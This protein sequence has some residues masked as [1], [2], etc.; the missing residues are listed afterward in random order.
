MNFNE[1][2]ALVPDLVPDIQA[3]GFGA[4]FTQHQADTLIKCKQY[5]VQPD[6]FSPLGIIAITWMNESSFEDFPTYNDNHEKNPCHVPLLMDFGPMQLNAAW[7]LKSICNRDYLSMPFTHQ[8][9]FGSYGLNGEKF[10]GSVIA[11][12]VIGA[13]RLAFLPGSFEDKTA[14]YTGEI[15]RQAHRRSDYQ[16]FYS[17]FEIFF[18]NYLG[19]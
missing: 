12:L 17:R 15:T 16:K 4:D 19:T 8:Q 14:V 18:N 3:R 13:R 5:L 7:T 2:I 6:K 9:I 11:N 1:A 10:D